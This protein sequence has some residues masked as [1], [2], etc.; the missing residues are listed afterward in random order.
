M[1]DKTAAELEQEA[2]VAR[3]R[4]AGTAEVLRSKMSPGQLIDEFSGVFRGGDGSQAIGNLKNQIRDNPLP[5]ALVGAGLAWL[6][7]GSGPKTRQHSSV[8][9][10]RDDWSYGGAEASWADEDDVDWSNASYEDG[11][12]MSMGGRSGRSRSSRSAM[13]SVAGAMSGAAG[14]VSSVAGDVAHGAKAAAGGLASAASGIASVASGIAST[15]SNAVHAVGDMASSAGSSVG[16]MASAAGSTASHLAES[17]GGMARSGA[18]MASRAARHAGRAGG[19]MRHMARDMGSSAQHAAARIKEQDPLILAA[20]GL[21]MGAA[22]GAML[23]QTRVENES[24]GAQRDRLKDQAA[25]LVS[26]G[27]ES[28]KEMAAD[29]YETVRTEA[30]RQ[31]LTEGLSSGEPG[32]IVDKVTGVVKSAVSQMETNVRSKLDDQSTT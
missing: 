25:K 29:A 22:I 23:P 7:L 21:A 9:G 17:A 20:L 5:L 30:D 10:S 11:G 28:A 27:V 4:M 6:M 31:G 26:D 8:S 16:D 12:E 15:A 3:S 32:S 24:F 13:R 14:M 18:G 19:S 2:E 1:N